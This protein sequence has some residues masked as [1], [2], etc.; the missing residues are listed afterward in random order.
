VAN[1]Q[2]T[3]LYLWI[4]FLIKVLKTKVVKIINLY[5]VVTKS[6]GVE[7]TN[8]LSNLYLRQV[9]WTQM[10]SSSQV[11]KVLNFILVGVGT[12]CRVI[13]SI[14]IV[15]YKYSDKYLPA[16]GPPLIEISKKL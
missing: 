15:K 3:T 2:H 10:L 13:A 16:K 5:D 8:I 14:K 4:I 7:T 9:Y 6:L 11:N 1:S 12:C